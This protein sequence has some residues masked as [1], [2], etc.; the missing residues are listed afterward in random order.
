M[1]EILL[2]HVG[3]ELWPYSTDET[4][5]PDKLTS[6]PYDGTRPDPGYP[7]QSDHTKN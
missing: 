6:E 1:G 3:W 4:F 2:Q 7:T 5:I